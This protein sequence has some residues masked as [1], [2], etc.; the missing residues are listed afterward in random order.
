MVSTMGL[1][2]IRKYEGGITN[3]EMGNWNY[4]VPSRLP[5]AHGFNKEFVRIVNF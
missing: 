1:V 4:D 3:Y 2:R 5:I